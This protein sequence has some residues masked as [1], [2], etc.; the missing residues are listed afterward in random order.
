MRQW[1][2]SAG[3]TSLDHLKLV[4]TAQ[5][6]PGP[7]EVAVQVRACSLNFRDQIIPLGFYMGGVVQQDTVPLSDGAGEVIAV[8]EGVS[9]LAVG[10]RVAGIFFQDWMDGPPNPGMGVALG[11]PPAPGMLQ[12]VVV[13]PEHGVVKLAETLDYTEAACL[14]C[15]GVTAWNALMEGPRPVKPG[16][17]VLVLGT[18]GVSLLALQ[19][20]K[21]AGAT[22]IA[23]SSS[24]EKLER[25]KAMGADHVINYRTTPEWGAEA[26]RLAGGGVDKVV[27]VGGA[28][29]LK[30]SIAAVGFAGEIALIGVLTREGDTN[31]HGL[32]FKGASI[33]GIFVGSKG[34][35][36]RLNA[37]VDAHRIKPVVDRSFAMDALKDAFAYQSSAG[38]FGKV[39]I[40]L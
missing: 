8:G 22:V 36:Q 7:G 2:I 25:V 4:D 33:R 38:L 24:D 21:A 9:S 19:I 39:A 18:G 16:D 15:A 14:P 31:P 35:A 37:F 26:A 29:T 13:L 28:G 23:T 17:T 10:D 5:P 6:T 3:A 40:T 32:M 34:M 12:D 20:A 30:Q 27:E 11:A 1:L